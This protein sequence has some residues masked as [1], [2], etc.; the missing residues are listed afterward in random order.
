MVGPDAPQYAATMHSASLASIL[1]GF[2]AMTVNPLRTALSALGVIIGVASVITTL[3]LTDGLERYAREQIGT[4]TDL[5]SLTVDSRTREFR[6]GF[7]FPNRGFPVFEL[8]DAT[9][10]QREL[11]A[12]GEVT[13]VARG[14]AIVGSMSAS[15]H[16]A[17]VVAT[18]ANY[19]AFGRKDVFAGR[20]FTDG[21]ASRNAPVIVLSH[22]LAAELSPTGE[23]AL[24]VERE[25]RVHGRPVTVVGVMPP[26]AGELT[27]QVF[28]PVRAA[29]TT[30]GSSEQ[31]TPSLI[32]R[33]ASIESVER[34]KSD[35]EEWL[36]TRYRDWHQRVAITT[37]V[38]R[39]EQAHSNILLIRLILG[40]LAAI[41]LVVG[42]VGIMNVLLASV[43]ERTREI[44]VRKAMGAR[45]R[46]I[47]YQFLAESV[48]IA[49]I[50]SGIGTSM[51]FAMAFAIAGLVRW[52][53]PGSEE[54]HATVTLGTIVTSILSAAMIGVGFGT[55]PAL[56]AARLS[57]IDAIRHD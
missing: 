44:G 5:Q 49:G 2:A 32:V 16:A 40:A 15:P 25:V 6:D 35:I 29:A 28:V 18:L 12:S 19:L 43:A 27:F 8:A 50:G 51:G 17:S 48:A 46:D 23:A 37:S 55:F 56:R 36:A 41:S 10:L 24:M 1:Q 42:G 47:L 13:M 45:Q 39:L 57:P 31:V 33:A 14:Q 20:F 9:D 54:L 34:T 21:E 26:Y 3:A 11:G 38:A 53:V 7:P 52:Q 30:F 22:R 4:K